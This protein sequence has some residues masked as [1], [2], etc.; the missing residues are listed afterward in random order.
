MLDEYLE[1]IGYSNKQTSFL[2]KT[3]PIS[4]YSESTLLYNFKTI[5]NFF[6][7]N[8][9]DNESF[10]YITTTVPNIICESIENI[11]NKIYYFYLLG[12]NKLEFFF[13]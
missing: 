12:F 3:Y 2:K 9:V 4:S 1:N 8:N 13:I 10:I 5:Y 6:K 11:K 7:K